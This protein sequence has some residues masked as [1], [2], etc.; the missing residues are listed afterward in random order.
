MSNKKLSN[1]ILTPDSQPCRRILSDSKIICKIAKRR[2]FTG[3]TNFFQVPRANR[4]W[5][6]ICGKDEFGRHSP[7]YYHCI[8]EIE[9]GS[10]ELAKFKTDLK[11]VELGY[12]IDNLGI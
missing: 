12:D 11:L 5:G 10:W 4:Y 8:W 6:F 7:D 3:H 2:D 9:E 1:W